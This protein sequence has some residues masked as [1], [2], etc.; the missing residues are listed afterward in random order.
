M[1]FQYLPDTLYGYSI[2]VANESLPKEI[3]YIKSEFNYSLY[4]RILAKSF[5]TILINIW[6]SEISRIDFDDKPRILFL[7][8][9]SSAVIY[10]SPNEA[11]S[12]QS[13][14]IPFAGFHE[15][16]FLNFNLEW[17]YLYE[18]FYQSLI[19][20]ITNNILKIELDFRL[21]EFDIQDFDF[22]IPIYLENPSGFYYVQEIKDFTS[23]KES[24]SVE[25]LRI[26]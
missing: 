9:N 24:T 16:S 11:N 14:N 1:Y 2:N 13:A 15:Q 4:S 10:T 8:T 22:S 17:K 26:G 21:T 6:N 3:S 5:N 12:T 20:G 7:F 25:L 18:T 19:Q 23:S